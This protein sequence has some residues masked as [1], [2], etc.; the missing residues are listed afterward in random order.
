[1]D[2]ARWPR[3]RGAAS[4]PAN[5]FTRLQAV[6]DE[7]PPERAETLY[8][9]DDA[10][11]VISRNASP[12]IPYEQSLNPYRGCEHG[13]A[14]C[15]AR[16]YHEYL[17]FS[18]GLDFETRILVKEDA[19]QLLRHEIS[20]RGYRPTP[21][22]L[23]GVTDPYQPVER[24]LGITRACLE[25]LAE[26]RHPVLIV[27][28]NAAV[29]RDLDL[30]GQLAAHQAAFV[31]L[32]LISLDEALLRRLEPRT[33]GPRARLEAVAKLA[34]AGVPC[35]VLIAPVVPGLT[36]HEVPAVVAAAAEAGARSAR[37]MPLR[38]PGAVE[39][40]FTEWLERHE[41]NRKA[42]VL[43]RIRDMRSGRLD[44]SRF[45]TRM[46]GEG[47]WAQQLHAL[48]DA[49]CRRAGL[50]P[51]PPRLSGAAFRPPPGVQRELFDDG[52]AP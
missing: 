23:S 31:W 21:L 20:R 1:M 8:L 41:P 46:T 39:T 50:E 24:R 6:P 9:R 7:G 25:V 47:V 29:T 5:R 43:N 3:G 4:D 22:D 10:R 52:D 48:F 18:A 11:S 32:S 38:L 44:D 51:E 33:S 28:K 49:A 42:K 12:D 34:A 14:Y 13:C 45:G 35:G 37:C 17:G 15:Y 19:G 26:S 40:V 27:T 16:T 30:L 36:D 2:D